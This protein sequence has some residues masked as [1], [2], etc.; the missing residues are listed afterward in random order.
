M[1]RELDPV[2]AER[3]GRSH[4]APVGLAKLTLYTSRTAETVAKV[5]YFSTVP[6]DYGSLPWLPVIVGGSDF[7]SGFTHLGDSDDLTAFEQSFDLHLGNREILGDRLV[8]LLRAYNVEGASIEISQLLVDSIPSFPLDLSDYSGDEHTILFRGR[9]ERLAPVTDEKV[10]LACR[11]ELPS[12]AGIWNYATS[13]GANDP[14]DLG[15]RYPQV[16]GEAKRIPLIGTQVGR[17]TTLSEPI[18]ST[19]TG[20]IEVTN[21]DGFYPGSSFYIRIDGE[22]IYCSASADQTITITSRHSLGS[23]AA[24]HE[25]GALVS[26]MPSSVEYTIANHQIDHLWDLYVI[27]PLNGMLLRLDATA[28]PWTTTLTD[29]AKV[30]FSRTQLADLVEYFNAQNIAVGGITQQPTFT[31]ESSGASVVRIPLTAHQ[32]SG[33]ALNPGGNDGPLYSDTVIQTSSPR[34]LALWHSS[35]S[36]EQ[37]I[38]VWCPT[39]SAP[40]GSATVVR[41]RVIANID[42]APNSG[43]YGEVK[44]SFDF[45]GE[46]GNMTKTMSAGASDQLG[47]VIASAW[48]D[49]GGGASGKTVVNIERSTAPTTNGHE[50]YLSFYLRGDSG[51]TANGGANLWIDSCYVEVEI[52]SEV[53]VSPGDEVIASSGAGTGFGLRFY[54]DVRG[55]ECPA[56]PE[57]Y[58]V[59]QAFDSGD[60]WESANCTAQEIVTKPYEGTHS[61]AIVADHSSGGSVVI[62]TESLTSWTSSNCNLALVTGEDHSEGSNAIEAAATV[63][64]N[65][66]LDYADGVLSL[67]FD[68]TG[69]HEADGRKQLSIDVKVKKAGVLGGDIRV[70]VEDGSGNSQQ[71]YVPVAD[72]TEDTWATIHFNEE[73][74]DAISGTVDWTDIAELRLTFNTASRTASAKLYVDNIRLIPGTHVAQKND[75]PGVDF[76]GFEDNSRLYIWKD[77][78]ENATIWDNDPTLDVIYTDEIETGTTLPTN[79]KSRAQGYNAAEQTWKMRDKSGA[80]T[81]GTPDETDVRTLRFVYRTPPGWWN[82]DSV[83]NHRIYIDS[84]QMRNNVRPEYYHV[85]GDVMTRSFEI[86]RHWIEEIGGEQIDASNYA[87]LEAALG[88]NFKFAFDARSTGLTW[89]ECL[90]RMAFEARINVIPVETA[91]GR[92]WR[93]LSA[94]TDYGFGTATDVISQ[95]HSIRD[96]GRGTDDLASYFTFRYAFDASLNGKGEEGF[97]NEAHA[98]PDGSTVDQSTTQLTNAAARFGAI[99]A[100]P[101]L[102]HCIDDPV[103]MQDVG[104]WI[105]Q[106]R[107]DNE[108][109]VFELTGVAWFDALPYVPGDLVSITPPWSTTA[110]NCRITSMTKAFESNEWTITAVEVLAVGTRV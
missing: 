3:A 41:F 50:N 14:L 56:V 22:M 13:E 69:F 109:R 18:D 5:F 17:I 59:V 100:A 76:T 7:Y 58:D 65:A 97:T 11:T 89:A 72:L 110:S 19:Q 23:V 43:T 35:V 67:D 36:Q 24:T 68:G 51:M 46:G 94:D 73:M 61:L 2:Q 74:R 31:G 91:N 54:A 101:I 64:S 70:R 102:F 40:N 33:T 77:Y 98:R 86:I 9:V 71:G 88:S 90:A 42:A 6:V 21:G 25:A 30:S 62:S 20:S 39:G 37:G 15:K 92:R 106:E 57:G 28:T 82:R 32:Q 95:V 47:I 48:E 55:M 8:N 52:E 99:E 26:E 63:D 96:I 83:P 79:Y 87:D 84:F 105:A 4:I 103:T 34:T 81:T 10:T 60:N 66:Y 80:A 53:T 104:G 107:S 75:I 1:S 85:V 27:N 44:F 49:F 78:V 16:Y 38:S 12:M 93:M 45:Y 29:P 108:R